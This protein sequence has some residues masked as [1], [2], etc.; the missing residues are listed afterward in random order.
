MSR[1]AVDIHRGQLRLNQRPRILQERRFHVRSIAVHPLQRHLLFEVGDLMDIDQPRRALIR[2][3]GNALKC[4]HLA[5]VSLKRRLGRRAAD[6]IGLGD[7]R[8]AGNVRRAA[9]ERGELDGAR[10][11]FQLARHLIGQIARRAGQALVAECVHEVRVIGKL[12]DIAPVRQLH[13]LADGDDDGSALPLHPLHLVDK[14]LDAKRHLR[15][16]DHVHALAVLAARQR[17]RRGQPARVAPHDFHNGDVVRAVYRRIP[18]DFLHHHADILCRRA[19][20]RRVVGVHQVVVDGLRHAHEADVAADALGVIAQ[21]ADRVHAVVAADVEEVADIQLFEDGE[22]LFIHVRVR[23][24]VRQLITAA[25]QIRGRRALEQL[26]FKGRAERRGQIGHAIIEQPR[27]AVEHA[28]NAVRAAHHTGL[29]HACKA[30]VDD[31]R[32]AAALTDDCIISHVNLQKVNFQAITMFIIVQ[33]HGAFKY[34]RSKFF[35]FS[36]RDCQV[37]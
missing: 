21:L 3:V 36:V 13:A 22:Q 2:V 7:V 14:M 33:S 32:R 27:H 26:D 19:V 31:R 29:K 6:L 18:D 17:R 12:A 24:A 10:L 25:P 9:L 37:V 23:Q 11:G 5:R 34:F 15:Q 35:I 28:V 30:R 8:A 16:A 1:Q 4:D 20:A